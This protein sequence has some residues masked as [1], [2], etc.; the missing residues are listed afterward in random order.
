VSYN[1]QLSDIPT[2]ADEQIEIVTA[3]TKF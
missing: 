1:N 2:T 3:G